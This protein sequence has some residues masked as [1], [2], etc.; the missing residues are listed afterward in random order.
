M[1]EAGSSVDSVDRNEDFEVITDNLVRSR[2]FVKK[3]AQ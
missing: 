1:P 3:I 2:H